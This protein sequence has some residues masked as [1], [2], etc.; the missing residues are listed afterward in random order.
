MSAWSQHA[1]DLV[2]A[3]LR[4]GDVMEAFD[5]HHQVEASISEWKE[6]ARDDVRDSVGI[7]RD[8]EPRDAGR[9]RKKIVVG[10]GAAEEIEDVNGSNFGD[11][12]IGDAAANRLFGDSGND[13][14]KGAGGADTISGGGD[15]DTLLGG[16]GADL[17]NGGSGVDLMT[18]EAGNE[19]G[20]A[21]CRERVL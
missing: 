8:V 16:D 12:I 14:I 2:H 17:L 13:L 7:T 20:R 21:S 3:L 4:D 1:P 5:A 10:P 19:I 15:N 9:R 11:S 18:G 6:V